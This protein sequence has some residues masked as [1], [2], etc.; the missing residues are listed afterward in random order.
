M[1][2]EAQCS[3]CKNAKPSGTP[4]AGVEPQSAKYSTG[5]PNELH[6]PVRP[7]PFLY[8]ATGDETTFTDG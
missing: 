5:L 8:E 6:G 3:E 4:L 7:L 1:T 2:E